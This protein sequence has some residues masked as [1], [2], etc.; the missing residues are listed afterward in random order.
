MGVIERVDDSKEII[1]AGNNDL[2]LNI[3]ELLS[4]RHFVT[5]VGPEATEIVGRQFQTLKS[6][7]QVTEP[8]ICRNHR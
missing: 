1:V 3:V 8:S 2:A 6:L 7:P 4:H 5:L